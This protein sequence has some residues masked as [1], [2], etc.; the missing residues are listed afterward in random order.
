MNKEIE[1][2]APNPLLAQ[3]V[4]NLIEQQ[5]GPDEAFKREICAAIAKVYGTP[6]EQAMA[7][8]GPAPSR[9]AAA[10]MRAQIENI[11]GGSNG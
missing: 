10:H 8:F 4:R 11:Y 3:A 9:S 6:L 1:P 7:E 5:S 2:T